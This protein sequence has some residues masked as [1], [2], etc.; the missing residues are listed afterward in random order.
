MEYHSRIARRRP[1][2]GVDTDN[3]VFEA[4]GEAAAIAHASELTEQFLGG[5][6]GVAVLSDHAWG[7]V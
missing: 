2:G 1:Q 4:P 6:P 7:I 3:P 5:E